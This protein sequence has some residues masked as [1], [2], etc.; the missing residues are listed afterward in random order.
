MANVDAL[1]AAVP[2]ANP[3]ACIVHARKAE[4]MPFEGKHMIFSGFEMVEEA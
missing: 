4:P 3:E 2:T 1:V